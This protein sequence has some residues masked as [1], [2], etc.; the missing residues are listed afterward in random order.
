MPNDYRDRN[1][2]DR[3][4]DRDRDRDPERYDRGDEPNRGMFG[5]EG[6]GYMHGGARD[7]DR[8]Y[9]GRDD[10]RDYG[11]GR[12]AGYR[13]G[14]YLGGS[15]SGGTD[16]RGTNFDTNFGMGIEPARQS[17]RGI[18]PKN[19]ERTDDR[20]REDVCERLSQDEY[21]DASDIDV[22]VSGGIVTLSGSIDRRM[23]KRRAE[24]IAE[25]VGGVRDVQN[26]LRLAQEA[27][28][29]DTTG[30]EGGGTKMPRATRR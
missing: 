27:S 3:Y 29:P 11:Y 22:T 16:Y 12:D 21:V 8:E 19:Y 17:F 30:S 4:R 26:N 25:S 6:E 9:G 13:G 1:R 10:N 2:W 23:S 24:D 20:I 14:G 18:G 5:Y 15:Y 7:L 28:A